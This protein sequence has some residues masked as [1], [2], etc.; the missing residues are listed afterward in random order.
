MTI[1]QV[2]CYSLQNFFILYI[3]CTSTPTLFHDPLFSMLSTN[4]TK[5]QIFSLCIIDHMLTICYV[6][7]VWGLMPYSSIF[8]SYYGLLR[9]LSDSALLL[10]LQCIE[11]HKP[12]AGTLSRPF[13]GTNLIIQFIF[14]YLYIVHEWAIKLTDCK[15]CEKKYAKSPSRNYDVFYDVQYI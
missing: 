11:N 1:T 6:I 4:K 12:S 7:F 3:Q 14:W 2:L 15:D 5:L 10:N 8:Q 13:I 9:Q